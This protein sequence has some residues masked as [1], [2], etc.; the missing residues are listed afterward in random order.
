MGSGPMSL[1]NLAARRRDK[2]ELAK[3]PEPQT[4]AR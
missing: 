1:D 2:L 3:R 4:P